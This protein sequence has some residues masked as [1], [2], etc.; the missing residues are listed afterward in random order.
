MA[1]SN[2]DKPS[3]EVQDGTTKIRRQNDGDDDSRYGINKTQRKRNTVE[4]FIAIVSSS[5]EEDDEEE[6]ELKDQSVDSDLELYGETSKTELRPA[7]TA[8]KKYSDPVLEKNAVDLSIV[9][10]HGT[11]GLEIP[12][13]SDETEFLT[14]LVTLGGASDENV[15]RTIN[16]VSL[17][18]VYADLEYED[19]KG[20]N[21]YFME[22]EG[23]RCLRC[24]ERGHTARECTIIKCL[25]CGAF[26]HEHFKCPF[27]SQIVC[28][29][30]K[31]RGHRKIDCVIPPEVIRERMCR[32]CDYGSHLKEDCPKIWRVYIVPDYVDRNRKRGLTISCY[33]CASP[34]HYGDV[35]TARDLALTEYVLSTRLHFVSNLRFNAV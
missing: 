19:F 2:K 21:R 4:D 5:S 6:G 13:E 33:N 8:G 24:D 31:Q 10:D 7:E 34:D 12:A 23:P 1:D 20:R 29:Q 18:E 11:A 26:G 27:M 22:N 3:D 32:N 30:C 17:D 28:F 9:E 15:E 14:H 25:I 35:R 16:D